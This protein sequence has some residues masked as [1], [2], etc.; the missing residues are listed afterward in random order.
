MNVFFKIKNKIV[1]IKENIFYFLEEYFLKNRKVKL[2]SDSLIFDIG[3]NKGKFSKKILDNFNPSKIIGLEANPKLINESYDHPKIKKLNFIVSN[4][5]NEEK[6][7]Y[8]N[9]D[10]T[11]ISTVS[12]DVLQKSRFCSGSS[13]QEK[14]EKLFDEKIKIKTINLDQLISDYGVPELIKIDVE[15]HEYEVLKGLTKKVKKITF[16]WTEENFNQLEKS[17]NFLKSIGYRHFGVVGFFLNKEHL[18][19]KILFSRKGDPFLLEPDYFEWE[20]IN[21]KKYIN[22]ERKINYGMIWVK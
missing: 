10:F 21:L 22:E 15:G 9:N 12:M 11:G 18:N 6:T 2:N 8:I 19:D 13:K 5:C 16:E 4:N 3:Y 14:L 17:I 1:Y 7:L 20:E